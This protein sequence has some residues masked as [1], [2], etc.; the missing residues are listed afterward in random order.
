MSP[1]RRAALTSVAAAVALVGLKLTTG[2]V[3][4]S[5]GLVSEAIH[6]GTD[7]VAALLTFFA[8]GVSGRPAD[9]SH[10]YGHGK[11]EHLTALAEAAVLSAAS[12]LI[13]VRALEHLFGRSQST[14]NPTW[15]ALA[16]AGTVIGVDS[17][18]S[19]FAVVLPSGT[20]MKLQHVPV[21]LTRLPTTVAHSRSTGAFGVS[22]PAVSVVFEFT[23]P[24]VE[25]RLDVAELLAPA[26]ASWSVVFASSVGATFSGQSILALGRPL[27]A[28]T[29]KANVLPVPHGIGDCWM[30]RYLKLIA[31]ATS[32]WWFPT[33]PVAR[34]WATAVPRV[35]LALIAPT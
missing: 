1:Q 32:I 9:P 2:L 12:V 7:F 15:Y 4:H 30:L 10:Q 23:I 28:V 24:V 20:E 19:A 16:V 26:E 25:E 29:L 21:Q 22:P 8:V 27:S 3:T 33:G 17:E 11:A 13:G 35:Q 14:V 31:S 34:M 5:L 6:S 18:P